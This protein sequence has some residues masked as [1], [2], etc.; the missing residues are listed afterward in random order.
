MRWVAGVLLLL[1][2]SKQSEPKSIC[3][4]MVTYNFKGEETNRT[5]APWYDTQ[6]LSQVDTIWC[7]LG[8]V[9]VT[10]FHECD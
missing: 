9:I 7:P 8:E 4:T 6:D 5:T 1:A 2:C 10:T 3:I